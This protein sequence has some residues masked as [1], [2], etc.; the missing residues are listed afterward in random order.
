MESNSPWAISVLD[1]RYYKHTHFL[2]QYLSEIALNKFR[3]FVEIKYLITLCQ[4][5]PQNDFLPVLKGLPKLTKIQIAKLNEIVDNFECFEFE[6]LKKIEEMVNHDIKAAEY[7]IVDKINSLEVFNADEKNRLTAAVHIFCTSEDINNLAYALSV[8]KTLKEII[9]PKLEDLLAVLKPMIEQNKSKSLLSKTHGQSATPTTLGKEL[10]VFYIRIIRVVKS[11]KNQEIFGKFNGAT[12]TFSAHALALGNFTTSDFSWIEFSEYFVENI[13]GLKYNLFTTQIES[14]DWQVGLYYK[15]IHLSGVLHN[16]STDLWFYIAR[17]IFVQKINE[18]H[19]G[20]ST[21]PHKVNPILFENA[22]ANLEMAEGVFSVL[23]KSLVTTRLQRDLSD[24]S[25]Q[26]NIASA[27]AYFLIAVENLRSGLTKLG[28]N[29]EVL[30]KELESNPAV[31]T[32]AVQTIMRLLVIAGD[33]NMKQGYEKLKNLV[34][35]KNI[36]LSD[37]H[38]FLDKISLPEKLKNNLQNLSPKNYS[39]LASRL[40]KL[41]LD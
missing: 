19:A 2:S 32:E 41:S 28:V 30:D 23:S 3:I 1:S 40:A 13:I 17:G 29:D 36:K 25:I 16:L 31:L 33:E 21:M 26:R 39:G 6:E 11:I 12:G 35:G 27:Y 10:A 20:S 37:L 22:E 4:G 24:S 9:I 5:F 34:R 18:S 7:Y 8:K 38:K 15:F 14:H